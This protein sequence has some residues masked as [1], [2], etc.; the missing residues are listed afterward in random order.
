ME[1]VPN[2]SLA[3]HLP[4]TKKSD[5]CE[6]RGDSRIAIITVGIVIAM[7]YIHSQGIIHRDLK[8]SNILLDWDWTVR[9]A[10][11]GCSVRIRD[12]DTG[13]QSLPMDSRYV[14][15]ECYGGE[16]SFASDVFSFGLILYELV[17][18][19]PYFDDKLTMLQIMLKLL[20]DEWSPEI[21]MFV[22]PPVRQ[23]IEECLAKNPDERPSF[24][25][26]FDRLK[27]IRFR[28]LQKVQSFKI[29][30]FVAKIEAEE[31]K[32]HSN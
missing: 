14:P 11:F 10:D 24:V 21:P 2:G 15:P 4:S 31:T 27:S 16:W 17:T 3:D 23:P 22:H 32:I 6:L 8:P 1:F 18:S 9:I 20:S 28:I 25:E 5:L 29:F 12:S 19:R 7:Q 13:D 26:I 30:K